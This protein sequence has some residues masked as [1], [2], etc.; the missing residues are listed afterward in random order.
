[1][2]FRKNLESSSP[3]EKALN[4]AN[5][6][7]EELFRGRNI[8]S[9]AG[10]RCNIKGRILSHTCVNKR[11]PTKSTN[12]L[13]RSSSVPPR[14]QNKPSPYE[15][16][17]KLRK[18]KS[19]SMQGKSTH[20]DDSR[21]GVTRSKHTKQTRRYS[22]IPLLQQNIDKDVPVNSRGEDNE[23]ST[24]RTQTT[25][26]SRS[27]MVTSS[28]NSRKTGR[29]SRSKTDEHEYLQFLLR[30]TEDVIMNNYFKNEDIQRVFKGHI[31]ANRDRLQM[32]KMELQLARLAKELHIPYTPTIQNVSEHE[33]TESPKLS[34]S[35]INTESLD[36]ECTTKRTLQ[37]VNF[38]NRHL[39][40][41]D[42]N[43][44]NN[45][46]NILVNRHSLGRVTECTEPTNSLDTIY[47]ANR[48][49]ATTVASSADSLGAFNEQNANDASE[50]IDG[51]YNDGSSLTDKEKIG[52]I[53]EDILFNKLHSRSLP[54]MSDKNSSDINR[55]VLSKVG[56]L[57]QTV[58]IDDTD[59][60]TRSDMSNKTVISRDSLTTEAI[61]PKNIDNTPLEEKS[62]S[63][64][65]AKDD[66][67]N[68][69]THVVTLRNSEDS[70]SLES[71]RK[72]V[73]EVIHQNVEKCTQIMIEHLEKE[74][75][76]NKDVRII[77]KDND[78]VLIDKPI[79][80]LRNI[81]ESKEGL[82]YFTEQPT[83]KEDIIEEQEVKHPVEAK[84]EDSKTE[85]FS[86]AS[87]TEICM[88]KANLS[89]YSM[90]TESIEKD[91][92]YNNYSRL[93]N[94]DYDLT[95]QRDSDVDNKY[96]YL[97][98]DATTSISNV[99][100]PTRSDLLL[101]DNYAI[102]SDSESR[103][104]DTVISND[105]TILYSPVYNGFTYTG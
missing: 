33:T 1:M 50:N 96:H 17:T 91:S 34:N 105:K 8:C 23:G 92:L 74:C 53:E 14:M 66:Q 15:I 29:S 4:K 12:V 47:N 62:T 72:Q 86:N 90:K 19:Q 99:N 18:T 88:K 13:P 94:S 31:E 40:F 28:N 5:V 79:Y 89:E 7:G 73:H 24:S 60:L 54:L 20:R 98:L 32:E 44:S 16:P 68:F 93:L 43:F 61:S 87:D 38:T 85:V 9:L 56:T 69:K 59:S 102:R 103:K 39:P 71:D 48:F 55:I 97:M 41:E 30:I 81:V 22:N 45:L 57:T 11:S 64:E 65:S 58:N 2:V 52:S 46:E 21:R 77:E 76:T 10:Q 26:S 70:T 82:L 84:E 104:R 6:Q 67:D 100:L 35:P 101:T 95:P 27:S 83:P 49:S 3:T 78:Y 25:D 51:S 37:I 42:N 36:C 80:V 75:N 63:I